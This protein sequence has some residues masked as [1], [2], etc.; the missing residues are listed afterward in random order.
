[1]VASNIRSELEGVMAQLVCCNVLPLEGIGDSSLGEVRR[2]PDSER[3]SDLNSGTSGIV[4]RK[5]QDAPV[6]NKAKLVSECQTGGVYEARRVALFREK[7]RPAETAAKLQITRYIWLESF[8]EQVSICQG[9]ASC[10][11]VI[12]SEQGR[13]KIM[14]IRQWNLDRSHLNRN[15]VDSYRPWVFKLIDLL[16]RFRQKGQGVENGLA[17]FHGLTGS[18]RNRRKPGVAGGR[19]NHGNLTISSVL[20]LSA[21]VCFHERKVESSVPP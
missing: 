8:I 7:T 15:T 19:W 4:L 6:V 10:E 16:I 12:Q 3:P 1:M 17:T 13:P 18:E 20:C 21:A 11:I 14:R 2:A 5:F 9:V